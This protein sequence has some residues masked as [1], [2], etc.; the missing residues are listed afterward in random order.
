MKKFIF[1]SLIF[2][3]VFSIANTP[4]PLN[5]NEN[6]KLRGFNLLA[7]DANFKEAFDLKLMKFGA[8]K[9]TDFDEVMWFR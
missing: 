1:L 4:Q 7:Y 3:P 6:C 9:S 5:Y 8:M 2:L